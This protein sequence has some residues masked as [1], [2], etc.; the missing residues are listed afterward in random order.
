M[1]ILGVLL[2]VIVAIAVVIMVMGGDQS[3]TIAW[4]AVRLDW[5][6]TVLMVFLLGAATL[7]LLVLAFAC[8]R[9]GFRR[10]AAKR[11][12]LRRLRQLDT[13]PTPVSRVPETSPT[14]DSTKTSGSGDESPYGPGSRPL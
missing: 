11:R 5:H 8:L 6:P 2:L 14:T 9:A 13:G 10:S 7:L 3:V 1:L 12:E 4:E